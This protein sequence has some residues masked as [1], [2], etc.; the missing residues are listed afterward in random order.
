MSLFQIAEPGQSVEK[1]QCQQRRAVG[2]DLGTTNTLV[3]YVREEKPVVVPC[4][5]DSLLI[6]S[7][8]HYSEQG[9]VIVGKSARALI[10]EFPKTTIASAKRMLGRSKEDLKNI[11]E[12]LPYD[13]EE[14]RDNSQK[15]IML[16]LDGKK[17]SPIEVSRDI[18][19]EVLHGASEKTGGVIDS[20][21]ITVPAYFD[22]GQ[23]QATRDAGRLA[24][25]DVL[26]LLAEPTAA[27]LAYGLEK[28]VTGCYVVFDLGGGTFDVSVLNLVDNVFKVCAIGG[29]S[30][31]G[32]DDF[33]RLIAK[34]MLD[35]AQISLN[36]NAQ[37]VQQALYNARLTKE[38]LSIHE[39][40]EFLLPLS[41]G[42]VFRH[43][44]TQQDFAEL[45][46]PLLDQIGVICK[47]TLKDANVVNSAI[48][49]VILVG[50][51]T[52]STVVSD[53][54]K[55]FFGRPV[56]SDLDPDQVVALGAAVQADMLV[57]GTAPVLLLDVIPLS[58]GIETMGGVFEPL[59]L[60]NSTIPTGAT[61]TYTTY[62]DNQTGFDIHVL[63]GERETAEGNRSLARF[64]LKG[65]PPMVAGMARVE[66]VFFVDAD[67]ILHV[68]A[69][70]ETTGIETSVEVSTSYGLSDEDVERILLNSFEHAEADMLYRKLQTARIEASSMI[71]SIQ[72]AIIESSSLLEGNEQKELEQ[73]I[74]MIQKAMELEDFN[75]IRV[76][77]KELEKTAEPFVERCMN[78]AIVAAVKGRS[79]LEI[80][81]E[82]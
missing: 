20:A 30:S 33:D 36:N 42:T 75:A 24:G 1:E 50:G 5:D 4:L 25:I 74:L 63:Q 6:P 22:D 65:I 78:K 29:D 80:E 31:L 17:I 38:Q 71:A 76:A 35:V 70:E 69:K 41:D 32:G 37:I 47:K 12:F 49:G 66:I 48:D 60:R 11:M 43:T 14:D 26:R 72:K 77:M 59:I 58:L 68:T 3:A 10:Q 15:M 40:A 45:I 46:K 62:A 21:V 61:N 67:G 54:V 13:M 44:I 79:V 39:S 53:Y 81:K 28:N 52:R 7:V 82:S 57:G 51:S 19:K 34:K 64:Y 9:D 18:I 55:Q 2:I 73:S 16:N 23:R 56:L 8:V 27:A